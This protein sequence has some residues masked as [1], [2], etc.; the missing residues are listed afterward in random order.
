LVG[1]ESNFALA[2]TMCF[3]HCVTASAEGITSP[4]AMAFCRPVRSACSFANRARS[5]FKSKS[6]PDCFCTK[7]ATSAGAL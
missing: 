2:A 5:L 3:D 1:I 4:R 7:Y 6:L